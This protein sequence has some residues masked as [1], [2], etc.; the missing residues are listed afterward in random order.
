MI[1]HPHQEQY[2]VRSAG[3]M[4]HE[5][6]VMLASYYEA[7]LPSLGYNIIMVDTLWACCFPCGWC[8]CAVAVCIFEESLAKKSFERFIFGKY[9]MDKI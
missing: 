4:N 7:G 2:R 6:A 1:Y 5:I 9:S 3:A 8:T